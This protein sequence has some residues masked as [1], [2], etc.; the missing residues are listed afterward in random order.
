MERL[1]EVKDGFVKHLE[2]WL[3]LIF[4]I[5]CHIGGIYCMRVA[6]EW[7]EDSLYSSKEVCGFIFGTL[8]L[9]LSIP[10]IIYTLKSIFWMKYPV[11]TI[12][13]IYTIFTILA[14]IGLILSLFTF[15]GYVYFVWD[16]T[17]N[18]SPVITLTSLISMSLCLLFATICLL[19][20]ARAYATRSVRGMDKYSYIMR[21]CVLYIAIIFMHINSEIIE[22][23][24]TF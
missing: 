19:H 21:F 5:T 22:K 10:S 15:R 9:A 7:Y 18:L 2:E 3:L 4:G 8:F 24:V 20:L 13:W 16:R 1:R 6:G 11:Y 14:I 12:I 23:N 17:N